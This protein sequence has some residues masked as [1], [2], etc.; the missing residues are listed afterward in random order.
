MILGGHIC[1]SQSCDL[2]LTSSYFTKAEVHNRIANHWLKNELANLDTAPLNLIW[3]D[4]I[5][6]SSVLRSEVCSWKRITLTVTQWK[7]QTTPVHAV[8]L[9]FA[10]LLVWHSKLWTVKDNTM[11]KE[12][13]HSDGSQQFK[14]TSDESNIPTKI[15]WNFFTIIFC[16]FSATLTK[17]YHE[18]ILVHYVSQPVLKQTKKK[19]TTEQK[20][21]T[22]PVMQT[23]VSWGVVHVND[24]C[25]VSWVTPVDHNITKRTDYL[26]DVA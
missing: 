9:L 13:T 8:L 1:F 16:H 11:I 21:S 14:N 24:L 4:C 19:Q 23:L 2:I 12:G 26:S 10:L 25:W 3:S 7:P 6:Y 17:W 5:F 18:N 20:K 22:D 15:C